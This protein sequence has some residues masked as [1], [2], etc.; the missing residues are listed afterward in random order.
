MALLNCIDKTKRLLVNG[1]VCDWV[2]ANWAV[3]CNRQSLYTCSKLLWFPF[4]KSVFFHLTFVSPPFPH[5]YFLFVHLLKIK[6]QLTVQGSFECGRA[7]KQPVSISKHGFVCSGLRVLCLF[8]L[9]FPFYPP[10]SPL[11]YRANIEQCTL[12]PEDL[13]IHKSLWMLFVSWGSFPHLNFNEYL[14]L[15]FVLTHSAVSCFV[16]FHPD[17][18]MH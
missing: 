7:E 17:I 2:V 18:L 6:A 8:Q 15:I 14:V 13:H 9:S 1:R 5:V 10:T 4:C 12:K 3:L 16:L 11:L